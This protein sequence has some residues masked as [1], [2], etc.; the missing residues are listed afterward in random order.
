MNSGNSIRF[1]DHS[2]GTLT[3][4]ARGSGGTF[5]LRYTNGTVI[6]TQAIA[7]DW[8]QYF[9]AVPYGVQ[10]GMFEIANTGGA[11]YYIDDLCVDESPQSFSL[12]ASSTSG[13]PGQSVTVTASATTTNWTAGPLTLSASSSSNQF[14]F[15]GSYP[16]LTVGGS[17]VTFP[18]TIKSTAPIGTYPLTV[19]ASGGGQTATVNLNVSVQGVPSFTLS[20]PGAVN[21]TAGMWNDITVNCTGVNGFTGF[22]TLSVD[23]V[24]GYEYSAPSGWLVAPGGVAT[25]SIKP[26]RTITGGQYFTVRG[27]SGNLFSSFTQAATVSAPNCTDCQLNPCAQNCDA[28]GDG[29]LNGSDVCQHWWDVAPTACF[30]GGRCGNA[31]GVSDNACH[32][33]GDFDGDGQSNL[34]D[35]AIYD[36]TTGY[37]GN[38]GSVGRLSRLNDCNIDPYEAACL[39]PDLP[40]ADE[41]DFDGD[42]FLNCEDALPWD[43]DNDG[44]TD[45]RDPDFWTLAG[46]TRVFDSLCE[47][48][49]VKGWFCERALYRDFDRDGI[50]N[51]VDGNPCGDAA[52]NPWIVAGGPVTESFWQCVAAINANSNCTGCP[53]EEDIAQLNLC[54][55]GRYPEGYNWNGNPFADCDFDKDGCKNK[56]DRSRAILRSG[57]TAG[58][59]SFRVLRA[60]LRSWPA[61]SPG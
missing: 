15:P 12:Q 36:Q 4:W 18:V 5:Q 46:T 38:N 48:N 45:I 53:D 56:L 51:G 37:G 6:S 40:C 10:W 31:W 9:C 24:A 26:E 30:A 60:W 29:I 44:L 54:A 7:A 17:S 22:V 32:M 23:P 55:P 8:T 58:L 25:I 20:S 3:F 50:A 28:D 33:H 41:F 13:T 34:C 27:S 35:S 43:T 1:Q 39:Q 59:R 52:T 16:A 47:G 61:T 19:T 21:M 2:G 57:V 42:G 14:E 11:T 49:D